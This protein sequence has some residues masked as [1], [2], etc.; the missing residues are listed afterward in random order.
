[1]NIDMLERKQDEINLCKEIK[2]TKEI[3]KLLEVISLYKKME[4]LEDVYPKPRGIWGKYCPE[5]DAKLKKEKVDGYYD[6][7]KKEL[8]FGGLDAIL[9][10]CL[11]CNYKYMFWFDPCPEAGMQ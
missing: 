5:C 3:E 8:G 7:M 4:K 1:M 10:T 11:K 6:I 9:Y 2:K